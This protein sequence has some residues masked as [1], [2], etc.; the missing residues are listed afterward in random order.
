MGDIKNRVV[1]PFAHELSDGPNWF[2]RL[3][4]SAA[5]GFKNLLNVKPV[6]SGP[7]FK[8]GPD[9]MF[10]GVWQQSPFV[11]VQ[12]E[13]GLRR[14]R[15]FASSAHKS[16]GTVPSEAS[17]PAPS[18]AATAIDSVPGLLV[19]PIPTPQG[20]LTSLAREYSHHLGDAGGQQIHWR[21]IDDPKHSDEI[22]SQLRTPRLKTRD[23][24]GVVRFLAAVAESASREHYISGEYLQAIKYL[25]ISPSELPLILFVAGSPVYAWASLHLDVDMFEGA[26]KQ[27]ALANHLLENFSQEK[28]LHFATDGHF[29]R[30]SMDELQDYLD[31]QEQVIRASIESQ[32]DEVVGQLSEDFLDRYFDARGE[33]VDVAYA[34]AFGTD[35]KSTPLSGDEYDAIMLDR[36]QYDFIIDSK[37]SKCFGRKPGTVGHREDSLT[38]SDIMLLRGYILDGGFRLPAHFYHRGCSDATAAHAF[39]EARRKM[40]VRTGRY[41]SLLFEMRRG[42]PGE[43]CAYRF[44]PRKDVRWLFI[45]SRQT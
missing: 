25:K 14:S 19:I 6:S 9:P 1:R 22:Y 18:P 41:S 45:D 29:T 36:A 28:L 44:A 32:C 20:E 43:P 12:R 37:G 8:L 11:R 23:Q 42:D 31:F 33:A 38:H 3:S 35:R 10:S 15:R 16:P 21:A 27:R 39:Y 34:Y 5:D 4:Y 24:A 7:E 30:A 40:D 26:K 2:E 13:G 17:G